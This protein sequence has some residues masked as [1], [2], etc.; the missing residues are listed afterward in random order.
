MARNKQMMAAKIR[1][2][3]EKN[4]KKQY[5]ITMKTKTG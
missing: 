4:K 1:S 2:K 3:E 5:K